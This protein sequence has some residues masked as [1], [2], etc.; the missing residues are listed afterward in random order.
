[1]IHGHSDHA[2]KR[3][4]RK[5]VVQVYAFLFCHTLVNPQRHNVRTT[6]LINF[7]PPKVHPVS[8]AFWLVSSRHFARDH[9]TFFYVIVPKNDPRRCCNIA[10][11][12]MSSQAWQGA[13]KHQFSYRHPHRFERSKSLVG[14][15]NLGGLY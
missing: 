1:M 11:S 4:P 15:F 6:F 13:E 14:R 10:P 5:S 2:K 3:L 8:C 7:H 12:Y 9:V